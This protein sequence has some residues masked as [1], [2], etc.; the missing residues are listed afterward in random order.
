MEIKTIQWA[1][2]LLVGG[3]AAYWTYQKGL[4]GVAP[5]DKKMAF[6]VGFGFGAITGVFVIPIVL[7]PL[8]MIG[9]MKI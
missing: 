2:G 6:M 9:V 3:S 7:L 1:G 8:Y 5:Q 4:L